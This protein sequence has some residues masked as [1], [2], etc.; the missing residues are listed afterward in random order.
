MLQDTYRDR[1]QVRAL[2]SSIR[3]SAGQG[4]VQFQFRNAYA[5]R[6]SFEYVVTNELGQAIGRGREEIGAGDTSWE[7]ETVH[8]AR[9][10]YFRITKLHAAG[11]STLLPAL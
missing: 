4:D 8:R 1:I 11:S 2:H 9:L 3:N 5:G 10:L 6:A 7:G